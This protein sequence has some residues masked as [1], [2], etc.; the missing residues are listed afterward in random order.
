MLC[1]LV[2]NLEVPRQLRRTYHM[3]HILVVDPSAWRRERR[4]AHLDAQES[5]HGSHS[6][7]RGILCQ[8]FSLCHDVK[9]A[10][11][12]KLLTVQGSPLHH[13]AA[14]LP[15]AKLCV[16]NARLQAQLGG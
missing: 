2:N 6:C 1:N 11:R 10:Q 13:G 7:S 9:L 8:L 15:L 14:L 16:A 3:C 4:V 5:D 12:P